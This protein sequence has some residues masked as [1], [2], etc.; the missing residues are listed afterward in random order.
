MSMF[1]WVD[2]CRSPNDFPFIFTSQQFGFGRTAFTHRQFGRATDSAYPPFLRS[3]TLRRRVE[4]LFFYSS[5]MYVNSSQAV[6][7]LKQ[8]LAVFGEWRGTTSCGQFGES[9]PLPEIA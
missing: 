9:N 5:Q 3:N 4:R 8:A 6:V 1:M 7:E 2:S